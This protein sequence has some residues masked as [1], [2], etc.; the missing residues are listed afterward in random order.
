MKTCLVCAQ[1]FVT[2]K[3]GCCSIECYLQKLQTKLDE[4]FRNNT[5]HTRLLTY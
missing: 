2:G 5:N 3:K 1:P 4:C